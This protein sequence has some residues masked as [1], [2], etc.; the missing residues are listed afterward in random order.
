MHI[1]AIPEIWLSNEISKDNF[2]IA[3]YNSII[4]LDRNHRIGGGVALFSIDF[5][6]LQRRHDLEF[7][8]FELLWAEFSVSGSNF[9]CGVC[10]RPPGNDNALFVNFLNGLQFMLDKIRTSGRNHKI[11]ILGDFNAHYNPHL[12]LNSTEIGK[13]LN[14]FITINGLERL[15]FEPTR[16]TSSTSSILY[17]LITNCS[18]DFLNT[19]TLSSPQ[20]CDHSIIYGEMTISIHKLH[21]FQRDVWDF[22][23]VDIVNLNRELQQVDWSEFLLSASDIDVIYDKWYRCFRQIIEKYIPFK[24]VTIRPHDKP[25]M[26][27]QVRLAIRKRDFLVCII[28]NPRNFR[29]NAIVFNEI[30]QTILSDIPTDLFYTSNLSSF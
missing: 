6:F 14:N 19:G 26:N 29:G 12:P 9:L 3:G 30:E 4:R 13:Q 11:I 7:P 10:Y 1:F 25:W 24:T 28:K 27:S 2:N 8:G 15:I 5:I 18:N 23:N 22:N 17:L 16:V 20:N 21:C